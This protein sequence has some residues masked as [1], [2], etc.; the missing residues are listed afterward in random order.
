MAGFDGLP[1]DVIVITSR[2]FRH[3]SAGYAR[4]REQGIVLCS[5]SAKPV[6]TAD[7]TA[8]LFAHKYS[9]LSYI[10]FGT[11]Q[12]EFQ[13]LTSRIRGL[14]VS[15]PGPLRDHVIET[16]HVLLVDRHPIL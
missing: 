2:W 6:E 1:R 3:A 4:Y 16:L 9:L 5:K 13:E 7:I 11:R 12:H 8:S 15:R 14:H 10:C